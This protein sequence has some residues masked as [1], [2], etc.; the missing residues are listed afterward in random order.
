MNNFQFM[1]YALLGFL[2]SLG[3]FK[4]LI[5][6][7]VGH[8][9]YIR[10][11]K[12]TSQARL[13]G[14]LPLAISTLIYFLV[15][16]GTYTQALASLLPALIITCYGFYDDKYELRARLKLAFQILSIGIFAISVAHQISGISYLVSASLIWF[17]GMALVNGANL[18]DGLDTMTIKTAGS[19]LLGFAV[20][21]LL[22]ENQFAFGLS[23]VSILSLAAFYPFNKEPA[24]IYLG[25]IGGSFLG[26]TFLILGFSNYVSLTKTHS[27]IGSLSYG[28]LLCSLPINELAISFLRRIWAGKS[29]FRGDRLHLH[30]ILRSKYKLSA[31]TTS[32]AIAI[33]NLLIFFLTFPIAEVFSP[34]IGLITNVTLSVSAYIYLC[35]KSWIASKISESEQNP[36]RHF[37]NKPIM[38]INT[39][40]MEDTHVFI[41]YDQ[42]DKQKKAA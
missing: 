11:E 20:V 37:A 21:S 1:P 10:S 18:L 34:T 25:E 32:T 22:K 3:S 35:K 30:H 41:C 24:K 26:L 28:L 7:G 2:I 39:K 31:S 8:I 15:S 33:G 40:E 42:I 16:S 38:L 9:L 19:I 29:P 6:R 13:L 4:F 27:L 14:G 12:S 36:F 17:F 23:I 5:S